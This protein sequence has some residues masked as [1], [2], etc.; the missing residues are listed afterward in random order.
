MIVLNF[1][2]IFILSGMGDVLE[3]EDNKIVVIG[4]GGNYVLSVVRVLDYFVYLEF[5]K[6][7][8]EFLKIVGDFCIYINMNIKI[9][10][11]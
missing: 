5:R 10:E 2:Y 4:S 8:E 3:V 11:F 7:V 9:L 6:F 1:D